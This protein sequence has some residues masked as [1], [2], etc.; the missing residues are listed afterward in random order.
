MV[1][2]RNNWPLVLYWNNYCRTSGCTD[3]H[4]VIVK[5]ILYT[6]YM[7]MYIKIYRKLKDKRNV[8]IYKV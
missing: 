4:I 1:G 7:Q 6:V 5:F 8:Y 3:V 2:Y